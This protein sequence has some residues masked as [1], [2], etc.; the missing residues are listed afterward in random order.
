M[1]RGA[2]V[3]LLRSFSSAAAPERVPVAIVGAGP[4]GLVLS[5][6]LSAY[7]WSRRCTLRALRRAPSHGCVPGATAPTRWGRA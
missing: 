4:T 7:G 6:L 5:S 3:G 2:A 1:N